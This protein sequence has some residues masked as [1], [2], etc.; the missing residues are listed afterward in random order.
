[1]R[2]EGTG[3]DMLNGSLLDKII[4]FALPLAFSSLLQQLF[5]SVDMAVVGHFAGKE[6]LAAVGS[7]SAVIN[8]VVSLFVGLSVGAN[9][10]V[11]N[12]IGEGSEEGVKRSIS[13]IAN[14]TLVSGLLLLVLGIALA[15]PILEWIDTPEDVIGLS[16]VYLQI[17]FVGIPFIM[18]FNFGSAVL[19]AQGDTKRPLYCLLYSGLINAILNVILVVGFDLG[20]VGVGVAT[21]VANAICAIMIIRILLCEPAPYNLNLKQLGVYRAELNTI[22]SIGLPAGV[23]GMVFAISN[24]TIQSSINSFGSEA[25]SGSAAALNFEHFCYFII[26]SFANAAVTFTGQNYAAGKYDRCRR[27]LFHTMWLSVVCCASFNFLFTWQ[28]TFFVNL[29]N[30]DPQVHEFAYIR[31]EWVLFFQFIA[32]S[33]EV[34]GG[35]LRGL[36]YSSLPAALTVVGTCVL[37]L[38]WVNVIVPAHHTFQWLM[39][40]YP[41]SWVVTGTLVVVAYFVVRSKKSL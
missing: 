35:A 40:V 27:V 2:N 37:R 25:M 9:V 18:I 17:Y 24:V 33:Y 29:F 32:S 6:A 26:A 1:M 3:M 22:V 31:L 7:N 19:R 20:V 11:A 14:V 4:L 34:A 5:N 10:V 8:L 41:I 38:W 28:E 21:S 13:T 39:V 30:T 23:Q 16:T 15:R 12:R 36:G